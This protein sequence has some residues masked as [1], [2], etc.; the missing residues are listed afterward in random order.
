MLTNATITDG[1]IESLPDPMFGLR[2]LIATEIRGDSMDMLIRGVFPRNSDGQKQ[3]MFNTADPEKTNQRKTQIKRRFADLQF[4]SLMSN[5]PDTR[6]EDAE[7]TKTLMTVMHVMPPGSGPHTR[8]QRTGAF[9]NLTCNAFGGRQTRPKK[10]EAIGNLLPFTHIWATALPS[11]M[12]M[13]NVIPA[14]ISPTSL[15]FLDWL[16]C[17]VKEATDGMLEKTVSE[18]FKRMKV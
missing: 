10:R 9:N 3:C 14:E 18:G 1:Q 7:R 13:T 11:L 15:A 4:V 5:V 6:A 12:N 16:F 2:S 17:Y 8:K